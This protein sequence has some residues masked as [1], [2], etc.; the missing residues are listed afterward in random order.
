MVDERPFLRDALAAGVVNYTAAATHLA[1]ALGDDADTD[2][3]T[4]ALRRYADELSRSTHGDDAR[5]RV[6][7]GF[8]LV[9]GR[10]SE[11]DGGDDPLLAVGDAELVA[12]GGDLAVVV[13]T[14]EV[15]ATGLERLLGRLRAAG[16]SVTAT[17]LA[18]E[19]L[20]VAVPRRDSATALRAAEATL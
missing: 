10:D 20:A 3:V 17:A 18:G 14:G 6:R 5:V 11:N 1:P 9:A 13:A 4:A 7:R 16:V 8:S 19:T 2:A 15:S 12:D